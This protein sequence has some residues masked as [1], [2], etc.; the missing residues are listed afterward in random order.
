MTKVSEQAKMVACEHL[1]Q[2]KQCQLCFTRGT[3]TF[4]KIYNANMKSG[5]YGAATLN[6][7]ILFQMLDAVDVLKI[8]TEDGYTKLGICEKIFKSFM[9]YIVEADVDRIQ[10]VSAHVLIL[11]PSHGDNGAKDVEVVMEGLTKEANC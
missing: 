6:L 8:G 7:K 9:G 5:G 1:W 2:D 4:R 11:S 3:R 10:Y